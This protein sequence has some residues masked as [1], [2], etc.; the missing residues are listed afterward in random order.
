MPDTNTQAR[1]LTEY[2][3]RLFNKFQFLK[4]DMAPPEYEFNFRELRVIM[5]IGPNDSR[6][7]REIAEALGIPVSTATGIVDRMVDKYLVER[8]HDEADRRIVKVQLTKKG[9][10]VYR[11]DFDEHMSIVRRLLHT[12]NREDQRTFVLLMKK[13]IENASGQM[14]NA[15]T[16]KQEI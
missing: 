6:I 4:T 1:Q 7:M 8:V 11:W 10:E 14:N 15:E 3:S 16:G 2:F 5:Y 13:I 12:L 9:R